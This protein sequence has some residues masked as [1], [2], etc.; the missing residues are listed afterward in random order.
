MEIKIDSQD[1]NRLVADAVL[2]SAIGDAVK[3]AV[4]RTVK[5]LNSAYNNPIDSVIRNH[6]CEIVREV[7]NKEHGAA[8]RERLKV[9]LESKL[10]QEFMDKV[11]E[12]A[13]SRYS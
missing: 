9:A 8:I 2:K 3:A 5:D 7:L 10:S 6:V 12:A 11:C 13:A 1:V 4:E